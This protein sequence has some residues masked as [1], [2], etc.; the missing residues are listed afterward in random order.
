MS[1]VYPRSWLAVLFVL[2]LFYLVVEFAFNAE[3]VDLAGTWQVDVAQLE[4]LEVVGRTVAGVGFALL[5]TGLLRPSLI[6]KVGMVS[7]IVVA[8]TICVPT[9][10]V[11]QRALVDYLVEHHFD[12][13]ARQLAQYATLLKAGI[14]TETLVIEGVAFDTALQDSPEH[15]T[16]LALVGAVVF[17]AN[18]LMDAVHDQRLEIAKRYVHNVVVLDEPMHWE[19]YQRGYQQ[20]RASWER[21]QNASAEYVQEYNQVDSRVDAIWHDVEAELGRGWTE[22]QLGL[23]R[24][25]QDLDETARHVSERLQEY[26]VNRASCRNENCRRGYD[27]T[28]D[29]EIQRIAGKYVSPQYWLSERDYN[30]VE[31]NCRTTRGSTE[32]NPGFAELFDPRRWFSRDPRPVWDRSE[33]VIREKLLPL[34]EDD[35]AQRSG[36]YPLNIADEL[37][38]RTHETTAARVRNSLAERNIELPENWG[39]F[40]NDTFLHAASTQVRVVINQRW[41]QKVREEIGADLQANLTYQHFVDSAPVQARI[42][43][44]MGEHYVENMRPDYDREQFFNAVITQLIERESK[45]LVRKL[46]AQTAAYADGGEFE[47]AGKQALRSLVVPPIAMAFSLFFGLVALIKLPLSSYMLVRSRRTT[48]QAR[49]RPALRIVS[50][51]LIGGILLAVPFFALNNQFSESDSGF[52]LLLDDAQANHPVLGRG[53]EWIIRMQPL[54]YPVGDQIRVLRPILA[55]K[56]AATARVGDTGLVESSRPDWLQR[57]ADFFL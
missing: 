6:R 29:Q 16:F 24:F 28:Y 23:D 34:R 26:F 56:M 30:W 12:A 25:N 39:P 57:A 4:R 40:K 17:Q 32:C 43:E 36:G 52:R 37:A 7:T 50:L 10:Y 3:L 18:S 21:Y 48:N 11:G 35:F 9:M 49:S 54:L 38:F 8:F 13:G 55:Y 45:T 1:P 22:Y 46:E 20:V 31:R 5:V 27:Q 41:E 53:T 47:Q 33:S 14:G 42:R 44:A 2:N 51:I 15:K 19:A